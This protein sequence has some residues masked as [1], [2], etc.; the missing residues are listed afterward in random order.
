MPMHQL[1]PRSARGRV[2][3]P[4]QG[5]D[6]GWTGI[7]HGVHGPD[8]RTADVVRVLQHADDQ[9][10]HE[11]L[12]EHSCQCGPRAAWLQILASGD[13]PA[14]LQ[15]KGGLEAMGLSFPG[16]HQPVHVNA[17]AQAADKAT[18]FARRIRA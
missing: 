11:H 12:D 6:R 13:L 16:L 1:P 3:L 7:V 4:S 17:R 2:H 14:Y 15:G 18:D 5:F 10:H 8:R 9:L